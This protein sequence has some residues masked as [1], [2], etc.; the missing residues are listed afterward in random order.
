LFGRN[1]PA[2]AAL[3]LHE[4]GT[5]SVIEDESQFPATP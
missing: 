4:N 3:M 5:Y 2:R 1:E